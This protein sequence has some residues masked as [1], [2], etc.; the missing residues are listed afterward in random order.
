MR[1]IHGKRTKTGEKIEIEM[2]LLHPRDREK[3]AH[4]LSIGGSLEF[5]KTH[6]I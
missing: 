3:K 5:E 2:M 6:V 1:R 4:G